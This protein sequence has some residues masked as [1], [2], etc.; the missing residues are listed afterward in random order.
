MLSFIVATTHAAPI[1]LLEFIYEKPPRFGGVGE[2]PVM[3]W[4]FGFWVGE[5][6]TFPTPLYVAWVDLYGMSDI[7]ASFFAPPHLVAGADA[8]IDSATAYYWMTTAS[9]A[10]PSGLGRLMD[11]APPNGR[12]CNGT[13]CLEILVTDLAAYKVTALERIIDNL[14][15]ES[16]GF[17][18]WVVG[19]KQTVRF[20]GEP[21]PESSSVALA[22]LASVIKMS[23]R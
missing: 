18:T 22:L 11:L 13:P 12:I 8:A 15:V 2:P 23:V 16:T 20:S 9:A 6:G 3:D 19:G 7:G 10:D 1:P 14:V 5:Q 4:E 17:G 21:V